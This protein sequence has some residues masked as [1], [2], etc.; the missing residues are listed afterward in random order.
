MRWRINRTWRVVMIV[1]VV[2][3]GVRIALP[4]IVTR[5]VNRVLSEIDGYHG[6]IEDVDIHLSRGA[7]QIHGIKITKNEGLQSVPF[8][9]I[10]LTDLSVEWDALFH[11]AL[12]GEISFD[13][14]VLNFVGS[15]KDSIES[16]HKSSKGEVQAGQHTDWTEPLKKL[17]PFDIHFK[18]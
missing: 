9:E 12:V 6:T 2:L 18:V 4:F 10:P 7:Y 15:K 3:I 14:P 11:G 16:K 8:V 1:L 13:R 17:M 5:Y